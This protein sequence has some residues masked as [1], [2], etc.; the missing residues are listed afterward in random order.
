MI[1]TVRPEF[2]LARLL[3]LICCAVLWPPGVSALDV[4]D[5]AKDF[6]LRD[7]RNHLVTMS[8]VMS[9][10]RKGILIEFLSVYCD[11][12]R[13]KTPDINELAEKYRPQGIGVISVALANDLAEVQNVIKRWN[14]TYPL[15]ADPDKTTYYLYDIHKVPQFFVIDS[16][17]IIRYRGTGDRTVELDR[18]LDKL[19]GSTVTQSAAGDPAP[20]F[21]LEN[22]Q[23]DL[24]SVRFRRS[25]QNTLL[26]FISSDD[27][28]SRYYIKTVNEKYRQYQKYGLKAYA[29]LSP[30]VRFAIGPFADEH[31]VGLPVLVDKNGTV[32][33]SF[34]ITTTPE[35]IVVNESGRIRT[36]A[37]GMTAEQLDALFAAAE[38]PLQSLT[39]EE[40]DIQ[41]LYHYLPNAA[42]IKPISLADTTF[43]IGINDKDEK[44]FGRVIRKDI[45]C[46][47]CSDVHAIAL[48]NKDGTYKS[49]H[50]VKPFE[51]YGTPID[52]SD[53]LSQFV[54]QSYH[55][56]FTAGENAD[57][58]SGATKSCQKFIE[59]LNETE[60]IV[61]AFFDDPEFDA[62]FRRK[63]CFME[64]T[65]L[66]LALNLYRREHDVPI[67]QIRIED[68][69]SYCPGGRMPTCP[70]GGTYVITTFNDLPRVMCTVHGLDPESSKLH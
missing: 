48:M 64:Q 15:L 55:Q 56:R 66:E 23:G 70:A 49:F 3:I 52:A 43:Y 9:S 37:S 28:Q 47:V 67:D 4:G 22:R 14:I 16:S 34:S 41:L 30:D 57:I 65:E 10:S 39:R 12:C 26:V 35:L 5:A 24:I 13:K 31:A 21:T 18:A 19:A 29:V 17:G 53:F 11:A 40:E 27:A 44:F 33:D 51:L 1:K 45:M 38:R 62:S 58:I 25:N 63:I 8:G 60:K 20:E 54:G 61:S 59:G 36:R 50:L 7:S 68:L 46:R 6:A 42:S 32:F 69:S 2:R